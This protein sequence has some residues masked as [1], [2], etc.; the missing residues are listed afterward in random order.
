MAP[1]QFNRTIMTNDQNLKDAIEAWIAQYRFKDKFYEGKVISLWD[2]IVGDM[3]SKETEQIYIRNKVLIV[4]LKSQA[5]K[6][7]LEFAKKKLIKSINKK[8]DREVIT[9]I[10]FL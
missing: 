9:D 7:E 1:P 4:K 2:S 8:A 3:I 10:S 6:F 5:L